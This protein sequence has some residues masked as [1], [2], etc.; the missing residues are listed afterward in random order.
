L[1]KPFYIFLFILLFCCE[2]KTQTNLVY[3]GDFEIFD[4]CPT[5]TSYPGNYQI[6]HCLG[7]YEPS[8]ATPDYYNTCAPSIVSVPKNNFGFQYPSSGNAY[9]GILIQ[10]CS[11]PSCNGWWVEY[12]QSKLNSPLVSG[13]NYEFSY[14]I[15]GSDLGFDY[16]FWKLGAFFSQ[17]MIA[18]TTAKPFT[19]IAPQILNQY[20]NYIKDTLNWVEIKGSFIA[21]GGEDYITIGYFPDTLNIDSLRDYNVP[22][23][24]TNFGNYYF[25]DD[26]KLYQKDCDKNLSN[27]FTP[28]NDGINDVFKL[29]TCNPIEKTIILNRWGIKVFET[30]NLN[31]YWDGRTTAGEDCVDGT[32]Y[33]IIQTK[34]KTEKGFLQL[35]R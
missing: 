7:W 18:N 22:N 9:C 12:I 6:R 16:Y 35:I 33:Y 8:Y 29:N 23:D 34:E 10:F 17:S 3:N 24:P 15:V 26:V 28:N 1:Y 2:A 25:V 32:Y 30:S 14:K 19:N 11:Q 20:N 4:T 21:Q 13:T 27:V 5:I 31:F